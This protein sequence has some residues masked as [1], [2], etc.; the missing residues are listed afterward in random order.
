M[1]Q[2]STTPQ[3]AAMADDSS[4]Q[5]ADVAA[6]FD[7]LLELTPAARDEQ[8]K[9]SDASPAVQQQVRQMLMA[10]DSDPD[11]LEPSARQTQDPNEAAQEYSSLA[12]GA[13]VGAFIIE[14]L[15]GR[16]GMGE[17]YLAHRSDADFSQKVALKL[18]RPEAV[19]RLGHFENE[20]RIL[21][22]LEH[23]GIARLIDGGLA[24]DGRPFMAMEFVEGRDIISYVKDNALNLD[25]RLQLFQQICEAV[26]FAHRNLIVHRDLKPANILVD[27]E[28]RARLLDFGIAKLADDGSAVMTQALLTPEYA[29]PEQLEGGAITMATDVFALGVVLYELLVGNRPWSLSGSALPASFKRR[30]KAEPL[31]PSNAVNA[32]SIVSAKSLRGDLDAIVMKALRPE[33]GQRYQSASQLWNDIKR[34]L[35]REPVVARGDTRGYRFHRFVSRHKVGVAAAAAV[36]FAIAVGVG[37]VL[38]QSHKTALERDQVLAE[39][40]RTEAV[41]NYL[42]LM[43]RTAG[44]NQGS[45]STTAKEVLD[46]SAKHLVDQY[47]D[48][49]QTRADIVEALGALYLYMNDVD[50]VV[51]LLEGY[52][53]SAGT[54]PSARAEVSAMLAEAELQRGNTANARHLL[55]DAQAFWS[56]DSLQYRKSIISSRQTQA[57]I[58]KVESGLPSAIRT[59]QTALLEHDDYFGRYHTET[60]NLLNS[61]GIAYQANGDI[62]KADAAFRDSWAVHEKVGDVNSAGALLT[63]GN[64]ATVAYRKN[65]FDRAE[66]LLLKATTLRRELYGKSAALAA[67]QGN[68]GKIILK[69]KRPKDALV[70]IEQA[71]PM[72]REYTGEH[73]PL[74]IAILQSLTEARISLGELK[75]ANESLIQAKNAARTNSGEDQLLYAVCQGVE[76][77]LRL[78]EG[79]KAQAQRLVNTMASKINALGPAGAPY[80]PSI[81]QLRAELEAAP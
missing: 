49:P 21:A 39:M 35:R 80:A 13:K 25:K 78:A 81:Q 30:F 31:L 59:L 47:R 62:D 17:V 18:I 22:G 6:L 61:L 7:R 67:M 51:P 5:W 38:W 72:S 32:T 11:F 56:K 73:S 8:L 63:L 64:W 40:R 50:G 76:A 57:Q 9:R 28:G 53:K 52:L 44:E 10:I 69:A 16:G 54:T 37:G 23:P 20:R 65:D 4:K 48:Q 41:K 27:A 66:N 60:A 46:Q 45:E 26:D 19:G 74:T 79:D 29:A 71:L 33:P 3:D 77:R 55:N 68:L 1:L 75:L 42:L 15:V 58:E 2:Q 34:H 14:R 12:T 36:F 43:F 24:P 70:Q